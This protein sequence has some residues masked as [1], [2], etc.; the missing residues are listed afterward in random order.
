MNSGIDGKGKDDVKKSIDELPV[1]P[2]E[3]AEWTNKI[4]ATAKQLCN[5]SSDNIVFKHVDGVNLNFSVQ[6]VQSRDCLIKALDTHL[7]SIPKLL[8]GVFDVFRNDLKNVKFDNS[9]T[10]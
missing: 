8:Q 1:D 4:E 6:D 10:T 9:Q 5:D 7:P 2:K 3:L